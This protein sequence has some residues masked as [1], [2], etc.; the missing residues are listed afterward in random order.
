MSQITLGVDIG[1]A[2]DPTAIV[3]LDSDYT[4]PSDRQERPQRFHVVRSIDRVPL[5]TPYP[6]VVNRVA[7][8][9]EQASL[10]GPVITVVDATGV[11]RAVVDLLRQATSLPIRAVTITAGSQATDDGPYSLRVPK[12]DLISA[13]EVAM[14]TRRLGV[15]SGVRL[16]EDLRDELRNF[17]FAISD[18]GHDTYEAASGRH[19]DLVLALALA[20]WHAERSGQGAI[21]L[22]AWRRLADREGVE[23]PPSRSYGI[24]LSRG[25]SHDL[26]G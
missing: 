11:G 2:N 15:A 22:E 21:F 7:S 18:R 23:L 24:P 5:G 16:A 4:R 8:V 19:D 9:A 14:Q 1:Q 12:R 13:L 25:V 3:V 17:T 10:Y 20:V 6:L 26:A